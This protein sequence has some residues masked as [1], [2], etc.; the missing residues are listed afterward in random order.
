MPL[1]CLGP[2]CIPWTALFP[3]IC[4]LLRPVYSVMPKVIQEKLDV[5]HAWI[6]AF[7]SYI[8]PSFMK[9]KKKKEEKKMEGEQQKVETKGDKISGIMYE[10]DEGDDFNEMVS[11]GATV[12]YF[13]ATWCGPCQKVK[14]AVRNFAETHPDV[15][16]IAVDVDEHEDLASRYSIIAMPTFILMAPGC[17]KQLSRAKHINDIDLSELE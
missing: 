17:G 16:V 7:I 15:Q 11:R 13:T 4:M 3:I 2:V 12:L 10:F 5:L 1:L 14:P 6:A 8:T 9:G